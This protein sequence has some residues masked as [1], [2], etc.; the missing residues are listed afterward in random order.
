MPSDNEADW[1]SASLVTEPA[2]TTTSPS[3]STTTAK[4]KAPSKAKAPAARLSS[5]ASSPSNLI[6]NQPS[7]TVNLHLPSASYQTPPPS[8]YPASS[9][10][11]H[12]KLPPPTIRSYLANYS[13]SQP[14]TSSTPSP[15][16]PNPSSP[17]ALPFPPE[18]SSTGRRY[19]TFTRF[20]PPLIAVG[21]H[22]ALSLLNGAWNS[23]GPAPKGFSD[24]EEA[25]NHVHLKTGKRACVIQWA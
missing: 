22:V 19:Y 20:D 2:N 1:D 7:V 23:A 11:T 6:L 25:L 17:S 3:T 18:A 21:Q 13:L 9:S 5:Q 4:T 8:P 12:P 14:S 10:S 15:P 16:D 24:L